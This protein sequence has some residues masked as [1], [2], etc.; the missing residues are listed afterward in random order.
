MKRFLAVYT[1]EPNTKNDKDWRKLDP[2]ERA[3][4]EQAGMK[5]WGE[6]MEK[7]AKQT[8]DGGAPLG[9]TLGVNKDGVYQT[10]NNL[11]GYII[12]EA[13]SHEDAA[14]LFLNHPHFAIFPGDGVEIV[15]CLPM[16]G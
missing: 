3:T 4:R 7:H 11:C 9:K 16:P 8:I 5:A 14:K 15:E 2:K 6:W 10:K 1:G 12:I 13:K